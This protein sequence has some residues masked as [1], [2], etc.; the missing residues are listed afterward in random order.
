MK[1]QLSSCYLILFTVFSF[2]YVNNQS[3][4]TKWYEKRRIMGPIIGLSVAMI[5]IA[6]GIWQKQKEST[7]R[8][9]EMELMAEKLNAANRPPMG[10]SRG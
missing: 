5:G 6:L 8:K 1:R 3:Y 10:M 9:K 4:G 2:C 7:N